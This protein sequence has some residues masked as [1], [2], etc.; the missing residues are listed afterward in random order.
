MQHVAEWLKQ[1]KLWLGLAADVLTFAGGPLLAR[2]AF[3]HL[4]DLRQAQ[5]EAAFRRR[6][7][8]V[9]EKMQYPKLEE[10]T[11]AG[12]WA[13]RRSGSVAAGFVCEIASPFAE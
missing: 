11:V 12:R 8:R 3:G 5:I 6:F 10:A 4:A 7:P 9:S 1:Y 2:D 13:V